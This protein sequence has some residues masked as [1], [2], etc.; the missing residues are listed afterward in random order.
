MSPCEHPANLRK[1]PADLCADV[2][3]CRLVAPNWRE[4]TG[5]Q[6]AF[7]LSPAAGFDESHLNEADQKRPS[8]LHLSDQEAS[9][10][11]RSVR[12]GL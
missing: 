7:N 11:R 9:G 12:N 6:P 10:F 5:P 8:F 2:G 1:R 4:S 3:N